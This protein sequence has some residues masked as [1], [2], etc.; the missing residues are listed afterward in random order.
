MQMVSENINKDYINI[1]GIT[2]QEKHDFNEIESY[3][4]NIS[5][6]SVNYSKISTDK[7][8]NLKESFL[9]EVDLVLVQNLSLD[10]Y[11]SFY[12][13][14]ANVSLVPAIKFC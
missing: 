5:G 11:V 2:N 12:N 4:R 10:E 3:L 14:I 13:E 9:S 8:L 1:V 7:I 6:I